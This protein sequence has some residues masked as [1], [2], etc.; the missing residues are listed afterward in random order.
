MLFQTI[1]KSGVIAV[2]TV[3]TLIL[4]TFAN[5]EL[6]TNAAIVNQT[7][8]QIPS[9]ESLEKLMIV[10]QFDKSLEDSNKQAQGLLIQTLQKNF[11]TMPKN[12]NLTPEQNVKLQQLIQNFIQDAL[13]EQNSPESRLKFKNAFISSAK[14]TY[15]QQEVDAMIAFYG[16]PI[17]QQIINKQSPFNLTYMQ[18]VLVIIQEQQQ[19]LLKNKLPIL[20]KEMEKITGKPISQ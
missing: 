2:L 17:G 11:A 9:D 3:G 19:E 15:T 5:A 13:K 6:A 18:K 8:R 14:A 20:L 7:N 16:S 4:P 10:Q 1:R 12:Q